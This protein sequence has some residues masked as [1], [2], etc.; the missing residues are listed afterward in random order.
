MKKLSYM[1]IAIAIILSDIMCA[2]IAYNYANILCGIEHKG[3][4]APASIAFLAAIPYGIGI[5]ACIV[6]AYVLYKKSMQK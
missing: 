1:F 2:D 6:I 5:L 4:S 3:Y